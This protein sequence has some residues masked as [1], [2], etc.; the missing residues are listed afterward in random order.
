ML[1]NGSFIVPIYFLYSISY[2]QIAVCALTA[3]TWSDSADPAGYEG[4]HVRCASAS[5]PYWRL[6]L[7]AAYAVSTAGTPRPTCESLSKS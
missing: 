5:N 1:L 4:D 2:I 7:C 6:T 3:P